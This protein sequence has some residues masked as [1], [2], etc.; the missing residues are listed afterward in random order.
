METLDNKKQVAVLNDLVQVNNDRMAGYNKALS[1]LS[2][3]EA[4]DMKPFLRK[5][6]NNS[7][8][9]NTELEKL[10]NLY[11]GEAAE[12]TSG[13]GKMYRAWMEVKALF[14][15]NDS[16]AILDSCE[17]IEATAIRAYSA[18]LGEELSSDARSLITAQR[19]EMVQRCEDIRALRNTFS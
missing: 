14:T 9:Y 12:G 18:A 15:G 2:D 1:E 7:I 3:E 16:V 8:D 10:V 5:M 19:A 17:T 6:V 13:A 4:G 11:D